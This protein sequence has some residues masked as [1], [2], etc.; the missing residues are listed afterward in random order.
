MTQRR[1]I[2]SWFDFH[3]QWDR[4]GLLVSS[5]TLLAF[6]ASWWWPLDLLSHFR[7]QYIWLL[8][9]LVVASWVNRRFAIAGLTGCCLIWNLYQVAPAYVPAAQIP[10]AQAASKA[11]SFRVMSANVKTNNREYDLFLETVRER[12]PDVLLVMEVD[13]EWDRALEQLRTDYPYGVAEPRFDNFGMAL[14]SQVPLESAEVI[15]PGKISLPSVQAKL[16]VEGREIRF[17]GTHPLPPVGRDRS[18]KRNDQLAAVAEQVLAE[19]GPVILA[20]D[21]NITPWSPFFRQLIRRSGLLD[22]RSGFGIQ[23][24]WPTHL[25]LAGIPIDHILVSPPIVVQNRFVAPGIGS[26]HRPVVADLV[27]DPLPLD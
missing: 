22:S 7:V 19:K 2:K 14:L 25:G 21:L 13:D 16:T 8:L 12:N 10:N 3:S 17:I 6:G 9:P 4:L 27:I 15:Y 1:S 23:A 11:A 24:T 18:M 20:G 26:D 5:A